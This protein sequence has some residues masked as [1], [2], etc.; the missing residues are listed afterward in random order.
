MVS[1]SKLYDTLDARFPFARAESWDK[2][3]LLVGD[4]NASASRA[5]VCYEV[6]DEA[7]DLA[8]ERGCDAVV[9]Y[10]PLIF[11]PLDKLDFSDRTARLCARLIRAEQSLICVHTALDG[12]TPP[13]ALGDALARQLGLEGAQVHK[14]SGTQKLAQ[15][16]YFVPE[17]HLDQTREAAW[18]EGA[19]AIGLYDEASF[20]LLG[21]GTFR[22]LEGSHP[23]EGSVGVRMETKEWRVEVLVPAESVERVLGAIKA[24]HP[25]EEVAYFLTA[26]QNDDDNQNYG[27]LRL[28]SVAGANLFDWVERAKS[29][30]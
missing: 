30:G 5:M 27:P 10:H 3:G 23:A 7:L 17:S 1:L 16:V 2:V 14:P 26:L 25:Y 9:A 8:Q 13:H 22:P 4:K 28:A 29:L 20:S 24:V 18:K 21:R 19:G 6:T 12:A 11:R 15:L